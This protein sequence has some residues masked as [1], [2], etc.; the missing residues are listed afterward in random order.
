MAADLLPT[1]LVPSDLAYLPVVRTFVDGLCR[2]AGVEQK[3]LDAIVLA[4]NEA[5][6]NVIRHAHQGRSDVEVRVECAIH[7]FAVEV[8]VHD[9]G[10]PFQ[11]ADVPIMSPCEMRIGGRGVFLMRAMLDELECVPMAH[12]GN[13]LRMVK[14]WTNK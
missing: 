12:G 3:A 11:L 7:G 8:R 10:A 2:L 1:L 13:V 5:V 9:R 6:S 4:T 14:R